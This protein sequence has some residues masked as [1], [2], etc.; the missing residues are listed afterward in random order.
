MRNLILATVLLVFASN[1]LAQTYVYD[2]DTGEC[3]RCECDENGKNC[4]SCEECKG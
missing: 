1:T 3:H 4:H 2:W